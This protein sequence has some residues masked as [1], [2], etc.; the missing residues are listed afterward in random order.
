MPDPFLP[1]RGAKLDPNNPMPCAGCSYCCEYVALELDYPTTVR[2][3][4]NIYWYLI[5]KDVWV[6]I[7]HENDWYVQFNSPC[8]KL[9]GHLCGHYPERPQMCREY[10]VKEC[11]RYGEGE[12]EEKF[13]FKNEK[14]LFDYMIKRRPAM[15]SKL[16]AKL[17]LRYPPEIPQS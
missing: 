16:K 9:E 7:D 4:D 6:Y 10:A 1:E 2:D 11:S 14:D 13:L 5:H 3:F 12:S 15:F 8:E 17:N